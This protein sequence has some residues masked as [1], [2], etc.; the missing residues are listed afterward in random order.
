MEATGT[1]YYVAVEI[2]G[3]VQ[4]GTPT[5]L[6]GVQWVAAFENAIETSGPVVCYDF[7]KKSNFEDTLLLIREK[8]GVVKIVPKCKLADY[9]KAG[10]VKK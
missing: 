4:F 3:G 5:V 1:H 6:N 8:P 7:G 9:Q 10:L 2:G